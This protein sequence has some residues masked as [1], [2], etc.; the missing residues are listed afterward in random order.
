MQQILDQIQ[1]LCPDSPGNTSVSSLKVLTKQLRRSTRT[2]PAAVLNPEL[3]A[4]IDL[5]LKEL[6]TVNTTV[7]SNLQLLQPYVTFLQTAEE[8]SEPLHFGCMCQYIIYDEP[9]C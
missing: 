7:E 1:A 2:S 8:V 5:I 6:K 9:V 4:R 3:T